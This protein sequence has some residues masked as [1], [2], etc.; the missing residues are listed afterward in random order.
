MATKATV[1]STSRKR[2][3]L[4]RFG[5]R[6]GTQSS[7]AAAMFARPNGARMFDVAKKTGGAKYT[8]LKALKQKKGVK[9]KKKDT[10]IFLTREEA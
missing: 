8:L 4:D 9:V 5:W 2:I 7:K 1:K 10:V 6:R 3:P